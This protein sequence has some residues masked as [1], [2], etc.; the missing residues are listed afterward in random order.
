EGIYTMV[1]GPSFE[2]EAEL[3]FLRV[4]G[5]DAVGMSTVPEVVVARHMEMRVLGLSLITNAATGIENDANMVNHTDVL[6]IADAV[7][8]HF[9]QL[10][11]G[12][13][14]RIKD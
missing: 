6:A 4:I 13:V 11:R 7:R 3:R 8:P 10:V 2:T 5:T 9:A 14:T 12:I 1:A